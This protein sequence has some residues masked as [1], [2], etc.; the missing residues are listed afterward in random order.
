VLVLWTW[1][2]HVLSIYYLSTR[3]FVPSVYTSIFQEAFRKND[4]EDD[5]KVRSVLSAV[6]LVANPLSPS[7]IATLLGFESDVVRSLLESIQSL[8][9]LHSDIDRPV[10]S[11]HKS[12]SDFIIDSARCTNAR[13]YISLDSH[14]ELVLCCLKLMD[15]SLKKNMCSI[16]DYALNSEV[17]DLAERINKGGICGALE[18]ACRSWYKHLLTTQGCAK[19]VISALHHF[20]EGK[21]LFWLEVLSV[22]G[23]V[24]D[25]ACGLGMAIKWLNEVCLDR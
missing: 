25:A 10:H 1:N 17:D 14:A 22:L 12:F 24:G 6:A 2:H 19:D 21:F 20:L 11:F 15:K 8:L 9:T 3:G 18:Y 7:A 23:A 5:A 4:A 13:F 16:P